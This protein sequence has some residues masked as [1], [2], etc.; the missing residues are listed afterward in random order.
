[1]SLEEG[2]GCLEEEEKMKEKFPTCAKAKVIGPFRAISDNIVA[3]DRWT[4]AYNPHP[5]PYSPPPPTDNH[6]HCLKNVSTQ[7]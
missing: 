5:H 7:V 4:G 2:A 3:Y 1:M 6:E